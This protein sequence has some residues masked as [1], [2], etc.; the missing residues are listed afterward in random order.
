MT[1]NGLTDH[2]LQ[3]WYI[4]WN[5]MGSTWDHFYGIVHLKVDFGPSNLIRTA[6]LAKGTLILRAGHSQSRLWMPRSEDKGIA[7]AN[8]VLEGC[9]IK[10]LDYTWSHPVPT[11][12]KLSFFFMTTIVFMNLCYLLQHSMIRCV[13]GLLWLRFPSYQAQCSNDLILLNSRVGAEVASLI[14]LQNSIFRRMINLLSFCWPDFFLKHIMIDIK[15][16]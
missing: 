16:N 11:L 14:T 1:I 7:C 9:L 12:G 3:L 10:W 8:G 4:F 15:Q 6:F 5:I 2:D 13:I